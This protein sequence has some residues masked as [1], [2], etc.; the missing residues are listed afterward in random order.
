VLE[1]NTFTK[2]GAGAG[3]KLFGIGVETEQKIQAPITTDSLALSQECYNYLGEHNQKSEKV[4]KR[5]S[6]TLNPKEH[7]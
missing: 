7:F 6:E 2:A 1:F 4:P 5:D 3:V